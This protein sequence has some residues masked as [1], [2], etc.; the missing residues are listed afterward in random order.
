MGNNFR[1]DRDQTEFKIN[2]ILNKKDHFI[3]DERQFDIAQ[4][5]QKAL[6][7]TDL[8]SFMREV[9]D[10]VSKA[11]Q[12]EFVE[13]LE[14]IPDEQLLK[15]IHGVGWEDGLVGNTFVSM[16]KLSQGGF[17]LLSH[18]P[19]IVKDF[20]KEER[21]RPSE[22]L[23][24]HNIVSGIT[25]QIPYT[26]KL[27]FGVLGA[28]TTKEIEFTNNDINFLHSASYILSSAIIQDETIKKS[29]EEEEKY[30][31]LLEYASDPIFI[32]TKTGKILRVNSKTCEITG[33]TK[34]ELEKLNIADIY[35]REDLITSPLAIN[36]ILTKDNVLI[37]RRLLRKDGKVVPV[38][39][40]VNLLPDGTFLGIS[41][42]I[43]KR[44][45]TEEVYRNV[46]KMEAISRVIGGIAHDFNNY[47]TVISGYA[48]RLAKNKDFDLTTEDIEK[49]A[50]QIKN[51]SQ[52][53]SNLIKQFMSLKRKTHNE[54]KILNINQLILE[55][56]Q[57]VDSFLGKRIRL[58]TD[59]DQRIPNVK[60][61]QD[62]LEQ[63]ILHLII[64]AK[65]A[66]KRKKGKITIRTFLYELKTKFEPYAFNALPGKYIGIEIKDTGAGM[67][68]EVLAH[69]FEPFYTTK[70]KE[71][72]MGLG[73]ATI[74]AF[75]KEYGGFVNI[76]STLNQG[77]EVTL[78]LLKSEE[79]EELSESKE[80]NKKIAGDNPSD[81]SKPIGS[82][83]IVE[84]NEELRD[85]LEKILIKNSYNVLKADNGKEAL[86]ILAD[87][88][89]TIDLIISDIVMPKLDG[90]EM[91][92]QFKKLNINKK[93]IL[94]SGYSIVD[95]LSLDYNNELIFIPKPFSMNDL[96]SKINEL[97]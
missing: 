51:T 72:G 28:F 59:L 18:K 95:P 81:R 39:N 35:P 2:P 69:L 43:T 70:G 4:L 74:Y 25:V 29:N 83:L 50:N 20:K 26:D 73:L 89:N 44:L 84:D 27:P 33:Y 54:A 46:I 45:E 9:V 47:L 91:I 19:V 5:S 8:Q 49:E 6:V 77:T 96:L 11:L 41:R 10:T 82:I 36:E 38:E 55:M 71:D 53:A 17:T 62:Q 37:E 85:L 3:D 86:E 97:K 12:T 1:D 94:M 58:V 42:V 93:I 67:S 57:T 87:K 90:I 76:Q 34:E 40:N 30:E 52:K 79:L 63:A 56:K 66:M 13:I 32:T 61:N 88:K 80:I 22:L 21:F 14:I 65:D 78:Y 75:V 92:K 7:S 23:T 48:D 64:N 60:V 15:L 24:S 16:D 68:N 31:I